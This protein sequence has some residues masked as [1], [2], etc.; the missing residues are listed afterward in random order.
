MNPTIDLQTIAKNWV[1]QDNRCTAFPIHLVQEKVVFTG[2]D[3]QCVDEDE[4]CFHD[5]H[6]SE[7]IY[8][9]HEDWEDMKAHH[10]AGDLGDHYAATATG[11]KE[12]WETVQACFTLAGAEKYLELN[13]HNLGVRAA[14]GF[15]GSPD[16]VRIY[17]DSA[18]RNIEMQLMMRLLASIHWNCD[19]EDACSRCARGMVVDGVCNTC[20]WKPEGGKP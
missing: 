8:P 17:V 5:H 19:I 15:R 9:G 10:D 11:F 6:N 16:N 1:E 20:S 13:G 7:T 4:L 14:R 18:F 2:I 12:N 3:P